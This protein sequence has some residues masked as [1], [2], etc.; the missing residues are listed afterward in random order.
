MR[1]ARVGFVVVLAFIASVCLAAEPAAGSIK[2]GRLGI[3]DSV[4]LGAREELHHHGF[5][6][7]DAVKSRQ[8][9]AAPTIVGSYRRDGKLP[10]NVVIHLGNNG[11]VRLSDCYH[12]VEAAPYRRVF[13]VNLKVPR[14][15]RVVDN[16]RLHRCAKHFNRAYLI[17][18][19]GHSHD[20]P[21]WFAKDGLHLTG[22]GAAAY[23]SFIS[24]RI[25][26]VS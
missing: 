17:D 7:V 23:A 24:H 4:M 11:T 9:Y 25:A 5:G 22:T 15:W 19:Y 3:G 16:R 21:S 14:D 8:F 1:L 20:H 12:A 26:S 6:I 13:L 10:R 18:W 2:A